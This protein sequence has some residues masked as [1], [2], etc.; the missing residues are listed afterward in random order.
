MQGGMDPI[1]M[2][3]ENNLLP[4]PYLGYEFENF[5]AQNRHAFKPGMESL[6]RT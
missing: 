6:V 2:S 5:V 4:Q 1:T 3:I